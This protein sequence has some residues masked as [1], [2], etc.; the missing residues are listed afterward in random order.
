MNSKRMKWLIAIPSIIVVFII[1]LIVN[2]IIVFD[3]S[4]VRRGEGVEWNG[5]F[6]EGCSAEYTEGKTIAKLMPFLRYDA[7]AL[8]N[9]EFDDGLK[10]LKRNIKL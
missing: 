6:Y 2:G 8:G 5:V 4:A 7:I 3:Y 1:Y 9:H 10:V